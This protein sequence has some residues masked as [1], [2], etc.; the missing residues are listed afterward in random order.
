[1]VQLAC[2]GDLTMN[3]SSS[4]SN[5]KQSV[6]VLKEARRRGDLKGHHSEVAVASKAREVM[7]S[8][9]SALRR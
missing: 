1:M 9:G 2:L 6:A 8:W 5:V 7:A 3:K 4:A